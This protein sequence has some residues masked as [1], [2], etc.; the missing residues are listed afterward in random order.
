M[1]GKYDDLAGSA[2]SRDEPWVITHG[3]PKADN[4]LVT[5]DGLRLVDWDT[6][7][8]AP[9]ARDLWWVEAG[10]GE[11]LARYT[12]LTGRRVAHD[13]V[14]FYRL[15]WDLADIASYVG[16]FTAPHAR[17][18]DTEIGWTALSEA[19]RLDRNWPQLL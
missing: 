9:A 18:P 8:V 10:S 7:L 2:R 5:D 13:D 14:T 12:E 4:L 17:T 15:Q 19:L 1:L 3:E 16:W 11:E 6:A